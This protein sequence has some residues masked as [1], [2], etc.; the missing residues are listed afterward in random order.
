MSTLRTDKAVSFIDEVNSKKKNV[1]LMIQKANILLESR[2]NAEAIKAA[3]DII[4][5]DQTKG[6]PHMIKAY[7]AWDMED[8]KTSKDALLKA[9]NFKEYKDL[10]TNMIG[11]L[12]SLEEAK[13]A[14]EEAVAEA[15]AS[16]AG[17]TEI[18]PV[19]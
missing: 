2:K 14:Y 3:D 6:L 16:K 19:Q 9:S 12:E 17:E 4:A 1:D 15:K 5:L 8:W 11:V 7:A 18:V 10:A 13:A